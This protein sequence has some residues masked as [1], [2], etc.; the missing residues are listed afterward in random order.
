MKRTEW[1]QEA[2]RMRFEEVYAGWTQRRLPC[3]PP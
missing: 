2:R 1:L 3:P